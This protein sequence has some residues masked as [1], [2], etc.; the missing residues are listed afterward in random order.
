[1]FSLDPNDIDLTYKALAILNAYASDMFATDYNIDSVAQGL[2][3]QRDT[4]ASHV[5]LLHLPVIS[6]DPTQQLTIALAILKS[7]N[8]DHV[9]KS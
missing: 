2:N 9:G 1:M 3:V 8:Y 4:V 6:M 7:I 5:R